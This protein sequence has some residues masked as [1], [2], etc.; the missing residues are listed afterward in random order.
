[1]RVT[2]LQKEKK[3]LMRI[4]FEDGGELSLDIDVCSDNAIG[5]GSELSEEDIKKLSFESNY[6][7]AK[8]R[9]LWYL[10]RA[11]HTE[12]ALYTK[13][14][15]AGFEKHASAAVIA[16]LTELGVVDDRRFAERF[17]ERCCENNIS[18]REALHKM[19]EKGVAYD[20]AKQ[21]LEEQEC[22]EGEQLSAL[23]EKK[24]AYKL[25][26]PN[27]MQKV[28]AALVRKGFSYAA[29]RTALKKYND[30]LEFSEEY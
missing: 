15:R 26:Q 13:L 16:R 22:D 3:H 14:L 12:K 11:D 27:G 25:S 30:E 29:I 10:D 1:M 17:A 6:Q 23:I 20:I 18:K 4:A 8:S 9:A 24:Y 7:R 2:A 5:V 21:V 28:Y 19:L